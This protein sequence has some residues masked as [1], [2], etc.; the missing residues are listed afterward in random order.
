M[1]EPTITQLG[2][3]KILAELGRGAMGVVYRGEDPLLSRAVAI[4]TIIMSADIQ[5][6]AEYEARFYQEAKAAGSLNHPNLITIHDIGR[7]AEI[8][9]MAMELLDGVE[10][11]S[12]MVSGRVA[13][14]LA[15]D[16]ALQV[17]DGLAYAHEHGVVHR[18][19]KPANIMIIRG[20]H[21]KIMD[22]GIARL[23]VSEIQTQ[24]G[25]M[26][27]SPKYMSPE[28]VTGMRADHRSDIF[29]LGII[30]YELVSGAAPF[31]AATITGLMHNI[32]TATPPPPSSVDRSLPGMLDLIVARA[33]EKEPDARYQDAKEIA[34]DLRACLEQL[35]ASSAAAPAADMEKTA[36][37]DIPLDAPT[38]ILK[39]D[40][41]AAFEATRVEKP[42]AAEH[43]RRTDAASGTFMT[44]GTTTPLHVSRAF[45]SDEALQVL[46][47]MAIPGAKHS[48]RR[49][50]RK[51]QDRTLFAVAMVIAIVCAVLIA[52]L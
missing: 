24:A 33:L 2:R 18:D 21:A 22:F 38:V 49:H 16:I 14:A 25:T 35:P 7:E 6:R 29:S 45:D 32:A 19:I 47:S 15:L 8:A 43:T 10:L 9:Y 50:A 40:A 41:T 52:L 11:R 51:N 1:A 30:I 20:R 5:E 3:Y 39:P 31:A 36:K 46:A 44:R 48:A 17:A 28:Q 12:L 34:A 26:L 4:K 42:A 13:L 23:R 27:G 37:M